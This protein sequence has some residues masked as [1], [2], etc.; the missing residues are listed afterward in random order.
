MQ[1][2]VCGSHGGLGPH[3]Q[4]LSTALRGFEVWR[5]ALES[6]RAELGTGGRTPSL[7][8]NV[9]GVAWDLRWVY[10][11]VHTRAVQAEVAQAPSETCSANG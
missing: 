1:T 5:P 7:V 11:A 8:L 2:P 10:V 9:R 4:L 3:G 6:S